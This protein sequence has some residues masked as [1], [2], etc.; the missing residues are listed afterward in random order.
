[1]QP[2]VPSPSPPRG[3]DADPAPGVRARVSPGGFSATTDYALVQRRVGLTYGLFALLLTG[4][5]V[6]TTATLAAFAPAQ[7]FAFEPTRITYLVSIAVL[8]AAWLLCRRKLLPHSI[9]AAV[10]GGSLLSLIALLSFTVTYAPSGLHA[11]HFATILF[12]LVVT[13][14]AAL[15][16]S[17]PGWTAVVSAV[18]AAPLPIGAYKLMRDGRGM[19]KPFPGVLGIVVVAALCVAATIAAW[20][21]SRIVYGLRVQIKSAM[22]L[23]QYT[24]EEKIGEG[25][26]GV[27]YRARH[28]MLRR[29]TAVKLLS[30]SGADNVS[31]K[32]FEREVQ[33]TSKLTHPNTIAIYDY[34]HTL[35]GV[36][37]YA[38]ELLDGV[39]LS[40]LGAEDGPQRP[41]RVIHILSQAA[42]ALAE[43]H[44]VGLIHR[45]VKP[46]NIF[47]CARGGMHDFVKVLDFGLVKEVDSPDTAISAPNL[48]AGT[49]LYMAPET[50]ARPDD[51]D[52]G[53]DIYALGCVG[54]YLLTGEP[55]FTGS[56]AI[57]IYHGHLHQRPPSPSERLG[58]Q[59]P[60]DLEALVMRCLAKSPSDRPASASDLAD[61][62]ATLQISHPWGEK[63]AKAWWEARD[64]SL[65]KTEAQAVIGDP[66][67]TDG[68]GA[69]ATLDVP[70]SGRV[71]VSSS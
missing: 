47:L 7:V 51:V 27:V 46:A 20:A 53:V 59:V 6:L 26:M 29:P 8:A 37:Y 25:G 17:P 64:S 39:T 67:L 21:I 41:G 22:Q 54:Y 44:S 55:P 15:V 18:A 31:S 28:A 58:R 63:E 30:T 34:G 9:L 23:G 61:A 4:V 35:D 49:P 14:R 62:L 19:D 3:A 43:A 52:A 38:M 66:Q 68:L 71:R 48:V 33:L 57:A 16:P 42:R 32:R 40:Q 56:N 12:A 69:T 2:R 36:F 1:M 50:I 10:D 70:L 65:R 5:F 45:D 24:L 60:D 11:E 13:L